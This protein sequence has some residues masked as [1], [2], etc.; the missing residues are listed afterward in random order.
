M[1]ISEMNIQRKYFFIRSLVIR[2][3]IVF[4]LIRSYFIYIVDRIMYLKG[5]GIHEAEVNIRTFDM[6]FIYNI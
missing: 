2:F 3:L 4:S 5:N 1:K 6:F